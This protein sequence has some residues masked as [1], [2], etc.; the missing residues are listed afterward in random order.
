MTPLW[1]K[2]FI[3]PAAVVNVTVP[4]VTSTLELKGI[5]PPVYGLP[6][7]STVPV[8]VALRRQQGPAAAA[9]GAD[10]GQRHELPPAG[11]VDD[12]QNVVVAAAS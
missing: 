9:S 6:F 12:K 3:L 10:G 7:T 5:V 4:L 2:N 8:F 1:P 11:L